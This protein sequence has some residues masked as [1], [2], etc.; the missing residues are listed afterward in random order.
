MTNFSFSINNRRYLGSKFRYLGFLQEAVRSL[1][2][3]L[4]AEETNDKTFGKTFGKRFG[5][6]A[7]ARPVFLDLFGG[8]GVVAACMNQDYRVVLND[9]L[10]SNYLVYQAFF[11]YQKVD[12]TKIN[13]LLLAYNSLDARECG[14]NYY[15]VNFSDTYLSHKNLRKVGFIRDHV[16]QLRDTGKVNQREHALLV[17]SLLYAVDRIANTF[18]HYDAWIQEGDLNRE[19]V[20]Y[21][22]QLPSLLT[23]NGNRLYCGDA[24]ALLAEQ[25]ESLQC[26]IAYLDPPY[27]SRQFGDQYH[28]LENLARNQK[29]PVEGIGR[30]MNRESLKSD[31]STAKNPQVLYELISKLDAKYILVSYPYSRKDHHRSTNKISPLELYT[32]LTTRGDVS[33]YRGELAKLDTLSE[34]EGFE[35]DYEQM[36][37]QYGELRNVG[38]L[39]QQDDSERESELDREIDSEIGSEIDSEI[40]SEIRSEIDS[41]I[42]SELESNFALAGDFAGDSNLARNSNLTRNSE[43]TLSAAKATAQVALTSTAFSANEDLLAAQELA[44]E[45]QAQAEQARFCDPRAQ[46]LA[47]PLGDGFAG[48]FASFG[49]GFGEGFRE[50]DFAGFADRSAGESQYELTHDNLQQ[51]EDKFTKL[52]THFENKALSNKHGAQSQHELLFFCRVSAPADS[53]DNPVLDFGQVLEPRVMADSAFTVSLLASQELNVHYQQVANLDDVELSEVERYLQRFVVEDKKKTQNRTAPL[54]AQNRRERA[55]RQTALA[56]Q[57]QNQTQNQPETQTTKF[58]EQAPQAIAAASQPHPEQAALPPHPAQTSKPTQAEPSAQQLTQIN[59]PAAF[60]VESADAS[61]HSGEC[62]EPT[63]FAG[64]SPLQKLRLL[65]ATE[66]GAEYGKEYGKEQG[67]D[68]AKDL[69]KDHTKDSATKEQ[70]STGNQAAPLALEKPTQ[71]AASPRVH[72]TVDA[73]A[74]AS[75]SATATTTTLAVAANLQAKADSTPLPSGYAR[76]FAP[77]AP[78][79]AFRA[80]NESLRAAMRAQASQAAS[81]T[82]AESGTASS[83]LGDD[84]IDARLQQALAPFLGK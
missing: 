70:A 15:S 2:Q 10:Y 29:P 69:A 76:S 34:L 52:Q 80:S 71:L 68:K 6:T 78:Y 13:R 61:G 26:E 25:G 48:S 44:E 33:V 19:L 36:R 28:F 50:G 65:L 51:L 54:I 27:N 18:G 82:L 62:P 57:A 22:P 79:G 66:Y 4:E 23:N 55:Q 8:T 56:I 64:L 31:Y 35:F 47:D 37:Q 42:E 24:N 11:A 67:K 41:E 83:A 53:P 32:L 14:E 38:K 75:A 39:F 72:V 73:S 74:S 49:E 17:T 20:L 30:K 5:K 77:S 7:D 43:P 1:C 46:T 81:S 58:A 84:D 63:E 59:P 16:D 3:P 9:L 21:F 60:A 12:L 45:E 40:D